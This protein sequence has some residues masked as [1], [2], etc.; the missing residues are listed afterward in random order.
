MRELTGV[1]PLPLERLQAFEAWNV[2]GRQATHSGDQVSRRNVFAVL[3]MHGPAVAA[4]VKPGT[5]HA[6]F[7]LDVALQVMTFSHM[8]KI[9]QYLRLLRIAFGPFPFLQQL[10]VPGKA[11]DISIGITPCAG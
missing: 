8:L 3:D 6:G 10:L 9:S 7:E 1:V 2:R 5:G 11:V 4:L